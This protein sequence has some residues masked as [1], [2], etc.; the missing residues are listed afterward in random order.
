MKIKELLERVQPLKKTAV[1]DINV[2]SEVLGLGSIYTWVEN[3]KISEYMFAF[4]RCTDAMVGYRVYFLD[5]EPIAVTTK[6]GRKMNEQFE[7]ISKDAYNKTFAYISEFLRNEEI[8][9]IDLD[10]E[11]GE[12]Y[13][14]RYFEQSYDYHKSNAIYKEQ[15]CVIIRLKDSYKDELGVY[16]AEKVQIRLE[17]NDTLWVEQRELDFPY[18]L[19]D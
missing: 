2:F 6:V 8:P 4:W 1:E 3:S 14:V 18:K 7:W 10:E 13:K 15:K 12:T 9:L 16:H 19:N 5:D 11:I 17:N